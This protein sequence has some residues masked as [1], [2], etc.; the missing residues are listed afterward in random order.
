MGL[1]AVLTAEDHGALDEGIRGFYTKANDGRFVLDAEGVDEL[2][3]VRGLV[4]TLNKYKEVASSAHGL[5]QKLDRLEELE[6]FGELD[7]TAEEMRERLQRLEELEASGG[8]VDEKIKSLR[9]TYEARME[10]LKAKGGKDLQAKDEQIASLNGFIERVLIDRALDEAMDEVGVLPETK[11]AV[12]ALI[13]S[14]HKPKV[15]QEGEDRRAIIS[16]DLGDVSIQDFIGSWSKT[17]EADAFM[18]ASD[19]A[20][21]G[22]GEGRARGGGAGGANPFK[23]ETRN[24]TEQMRL[25]KE[26]PDQARILAREAGVKLPKLAS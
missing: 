16:T 9:E 12:R 26:N 18:P 24:I 13:K 1:K 17:K 4:S 20:G 22:S 19:N 14:E 5:K 2:P 15:V 25:I 8:D 11:K 21:S 7:I 3:T 6:A 10:A 23:K